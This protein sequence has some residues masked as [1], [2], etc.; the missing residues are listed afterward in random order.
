MQAPDIVLRFGDAAIGTGELD[1]TRH[2]LVFGGQEQELEPKAFAVLA[3]LLA[4]AGEL[5]SRDDLLDAVWGH[6]HVTPAVLSRSIAQLRKVLGDHAEAPH[7]IQTVHSLGYRFIAPVESTAGDVPPPQAFAP[8]PKP[9]RRN[10]WRP[11]AWIGATCAL[12]VVVLALRPRTIDDAL[13]LSDVVANAPRHVVLQPF[14]VPSAARGIAPQVQALESTLAQRI[15]ALPGLRLARGAVQG[16]AATLAGDVVGKPGD[17]RLRIRLEEPASKS[18]PFERTYPLRLATF[19]ETANTLQLDLLRRLQPESPLLGQPGHALDAE[20]FVRSGNRAAEGLL[21]RDRQDAIANF[22]RALEL[23]PGNAAAWC[24]LGDMYLMGAI[25]NLRSTDEVV[26][27]AT[28]AI[29]RG[30]RLDASSPTCLQSKGGLLRLQRKDREAEA[31]FRRALTL[32]PTMFDAE[33][34]LAGMTLARDHFAE[35]KGLFEG[36]VARHPERA[37]PHCRLIY[38]YDLTGEVDAARALEKVA[39]ARHPEL[40]RICWPAASVDFNH[41]RIG[42]AIPRY[43]HFSELDPGDQS[44]R[45]VA[46]YGAEMIGDAALAKAELDKAGP[47]ETAHYLQAHVWLFYALRD[48]EGAL[49]WLRA[50]RMPPSLALLQR[51][52]IA[53]S[54]A[55][56]GDRDAALAEYA[57]VYEGGYENDDPAMTQ[58]SWIYS[59][60]LLNRAALLDEGDVRRRSLVDAAER[61]L[62]RLRSDGLGLPWVHYQAAQIAV[63]RGDVDA[64]MVELDRA[65]AA[66]YSDALSLYRDLAWRSVAGD[67]RFLA[68]KARLE[69]VAATQRRLVAGNARSGVATNP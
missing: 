51:A 42:H 55:L 49:A 25:E 5:R 29:E 68:R 21:Q 9:A 6:R 1:A 13:P 41:G 15:G 26:P 50:H 39:Y 63:L 60:Q 57:R 58:G 18:A 19:G 69:D 37:W 32:D 47:S 34:A 59:A 30:L 28:D 10:P 67:A 64:G 27:P 31:A 2:R 66:G 62:A 40:R 46:A 36:L 43:Q 16:D 4:H 54:L 20:Q 53:Q 45:L 7:F 65:M 14:A 61:H 48:P 12:V 52:F 44:Y 24:R 17:W 38:V 56:A 8:P 35:A 3:D 33:W 22:R 23:D 11:I